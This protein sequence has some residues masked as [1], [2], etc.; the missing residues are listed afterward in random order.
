[1]LCFSWKIKLIHAFDFQIPIVIVASIDKTLHLLWPV[2]QLHNGLREVREKNKRSVIRLK[3]ERWEYFM[4][5]SC[6]LWN[7]SATISWR[8]YCRFLSFSK[9]GLLNMEAFYSILLTLSREINKVCRPDIL[10]RDYKRGWKVEDRAY[11]QSF[12]RK[13][14]QGDILYHFETFLR[15]INKVWRIDILRRDC[16]RLFQCLMRDLIG[17]KTFF[18]E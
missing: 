18:K 4:I 8:K 11:F 2:P 3:F 7:A 5:W 12:L 10:G 17:L 13:K 15:E 6:K 1:M 16:N 9:N 14:I